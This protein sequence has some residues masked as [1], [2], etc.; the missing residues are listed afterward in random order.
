MQ[1]NL[2]GKPV[3]AFRRRAVTPVYVSPNQ[4]TLCGFETPFEQ[5]LTKKNRWVKLSDS[6]PWDKFVRL[7]D[8]MFKSMEGR[9]P[10]SGR[11]VIGAVII[12]HILNVSDRETIFQIRENMF[13][14]YLLG[15]TSLTNEE[16]F[17]HTLFGT[18]RNRLSLD[19][20]NK[21]TEVIVEHSQKLEEDNED[22][23][24]KDHGVIADAGEEQPLP[25]VQEFPL[26]GTLLLDATVAPQY[27]TF[28]TDLKLLN[29]AREKTEEL[30]DILYDKTVHC[31]KPR[32]YRKIARKEYLNTAK[33]KSKRI[34]EIY[35]ANGR[36]IRYVRRNLKHIKSMLL[37]YEKSRE[38][39]VENPLTD[40]DYK[41]IDTITIIHQQQLEMYQTN[42]RTVDDRIVNLHQDYVRPIKRGKEGKKTEFGSKIQASLVNGFMR[43]D[44]LSWDN[45][46]E[47]KY[48]QDS[49]EQY[50]IKY[51][52]YPS[53]VLADRIYWNRENRAY[54]K[55]RGIILNGKPLGRPRNDEA[56]SNQISPGERNPIEGKF[57]QAKVAYGLNSIGAKLKSTSESWIASITLVLNLVNL[58]RLAPLCLYRAIISIFGRQMVTASL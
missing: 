27:I 31:E 2:E 54:M 57:G 7:Y 33:K 42:T 28:P 45:F 51:G 43:I 21:L 35:T 10:I 19:F 25:E 15:Y 8:E 37:D 11:V 1:V 50:K 34:Q 40:R 14:Q 3:K 36:Q 47:G 16:P 9:P 32:T 39:F 18:I 23:E 6:I 53:S 26:K 17:S 46:N 22:I 24:E 52:C 13:M 44:K 30:I 38:V 12:K 5:K 20:M 55:D 58:M 48:L 41:Y 4:L 49:V 56:L 29:A